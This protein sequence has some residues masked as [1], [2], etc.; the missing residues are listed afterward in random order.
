MQQV[1][2]PTPGT[3]A[4]VL[5]TEQLFSNHQQALYKQTDRMFAVLMTLQWL[6]GIGVALWLS[7]KAWAGL[8]NHT[9][10]HFW[11]ALFLG[12][13]ITAFPVGLALA[14]PGEIFTRYTI[15]I[16]QMLMGS[17]LIHLSGGRIETHFHV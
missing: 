8:S 11:A 4:V 10:P 5:R 3:Q 6:A 14:R 2:A 15:S 16:G 7:P 13:A 1:A 12:G 9:H 17:L